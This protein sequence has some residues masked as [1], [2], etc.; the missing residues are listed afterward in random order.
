MH[1][2]PWPHSNRRTINTMIMVMVMMM[3]YFCLLSQHC[4]CSE[5]GI[6]EQTDVQRSGEESHDE[7]SREDC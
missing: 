5:I 1:L 4:V 6:S 3:T 2:C 7:Q